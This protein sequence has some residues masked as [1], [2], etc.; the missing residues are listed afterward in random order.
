MS[1]SNSPQR[2][3]DVFVSFRGEEIRRGILSHMIESF[4]RKKINGF[5][6]DKLERGDETWSSL[7]RAIEG[8]FISLIIIHLNAE[9]NMD[10]L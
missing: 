2:K 8:S 6:D 3:Y 1:D 4:Q 7:V 10:I 9:K 5:V